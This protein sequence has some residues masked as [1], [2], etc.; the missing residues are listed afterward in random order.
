MEN[1]E[2]EEEDEK[3]RIKVNLR[4]NRKHLSIPIIRMQSLMLVHNG[5]K[6]LFIE[7]NR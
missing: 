7:F 4:M 3:E 6:L 5:T 2:E 1:V